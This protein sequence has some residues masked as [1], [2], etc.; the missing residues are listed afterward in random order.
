M[1]VSGAGPVNIDKE[2]GMPSGYVS[3]RPCRLWLRDWEISAFITWYFTRKWVQRW[4]LQQLPP[5]WT[6][7]MTPPFKE[8]IMHRLWYTCRSVLSSM[9]WT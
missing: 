2:T 6:S 9:F 5:I 8:R 1:I 7:K 4:C 3:L